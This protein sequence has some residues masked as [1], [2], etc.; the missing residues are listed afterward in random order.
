MAANVERT[1]N[2]PIESFRLIYFV[3]KRKTRAR[4]IRPKSMLLICILICV[5][6]AIF[7]RI[8][9]NVICAKHDGDGRRWKR[10]RAKRIFFGRPASVV[11]RSRCA[12]VIAASVAPNYHCYCSKG[13]HRVETEKP[14]PKHCRVE[15]FQAKTAS[16]VSKRRTTCA[17]SQSTSIF[18]TVASLSP[19]RRLRRAASPPEFNRN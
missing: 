10:R 6:T 17:R 5:D 12:Q 13:T 1:P 8:W 3:Q 19:R 18:M 15:Y 14:G 7:H 9:P 11:V 16:N 2:H 4:R